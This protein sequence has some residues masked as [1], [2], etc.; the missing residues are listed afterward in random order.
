MSQPQVFEY[1]EK[2]GS[3]DWLSLPDEPVETPAPVEQEPDADATGGK[4]SDD[5]APLDIDKLEELRKALAPKE[6]EEAP[7]PDEKPEEDGDDDIDDVF[8]SKV[9]RALEKRF[10]LSIDEIIDVLNGADAVVRETAVEKQER[11]LRE[12]WGEDAYEANMSAVAE[13]FAKLPPELQEKYD[14]V[15]GAKLLW[16]LVQQEQNAKNQ[17]KATPQRDTVRFIKGGKQATGQGAAA[18]TFKMSELLEMSQ[19]EYQKNLSVIEQAFKDN[20]VIN[21][22][23]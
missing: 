21:D 5:D 15:E 2:G 12:F 19:A 11:E 17:R 9:E 14:N 20:R 16:A 6:E 18:N 10:G 4:T 8:I 23:A 3:D 1:N 13:R 22:I 7:K